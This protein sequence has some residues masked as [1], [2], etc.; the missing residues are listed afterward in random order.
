MS[1]TIERDILSLAKQTTVVGTSLVPVVAAINLLRYDKKT[2]Q[3]K[4]AGSTALNAGMVQA[5]NISDADNPSK[6]SANDADWETIDS[7]TFATLAGAA[8]KSVQISGDSRKW[9]RV[10][11]S[12]GSG[13]TTINAYVTGGT[14]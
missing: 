9:W 3:L 7:T 11:A 14:P 6:P 2:F 10:L 5:T 8:T 4:N 13:S 12:V 1:G